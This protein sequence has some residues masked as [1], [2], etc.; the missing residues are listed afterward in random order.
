MPLLPLFLR[1]E[2]GVRIALKDFLFARN[3]THLHAKGQNSC[4]SG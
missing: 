2:S 3:A 1:L 4:T